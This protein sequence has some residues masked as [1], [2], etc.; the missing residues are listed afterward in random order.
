MPR[1]RW[2]WIKEVYE[3]RLTSEQ[4]LEAQ[5]KILRMSLEII[6][7]KRGDYARADDPFLNFRRAE[8]WGISAWKGAAIRLTDKISRLAQLLEHG[9]VGQVKDESVLDTILDG[10]AYFPILYFLWMEEND[11]TD[12]LKVILDSQ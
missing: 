1:L 6:K 7:R 4:A 2:K 8:I 9:G 10:I 5:E 11:R 12:L 3:V